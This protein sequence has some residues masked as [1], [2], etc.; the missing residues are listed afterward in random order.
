MNN[1]VDVI[2]T[3][4]ITATTELHPFVRGSNTAEVV[5]RIDDIGLKV[6]DTG[7]RIFGV[8]R[9]GWNNRLYN[10]DVGFTGWNL[11]LIE[12]SPDPCERF[13]DFLR[14]RVDHGKREISKS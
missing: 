9:K 11:Q 1:F 13:L 6:N 12:V 14:R 4:I 7:T 10:K 5:P 8:L 3:S 2:G